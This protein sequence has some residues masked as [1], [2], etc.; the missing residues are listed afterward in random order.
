MFQISD[1]VIL[2]I[3]FVLGAIF[4]ALIYILLA[5]SNPGIVTQDTIDTEGEE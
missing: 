4:Q 5:V 3:L 2:P 1:N